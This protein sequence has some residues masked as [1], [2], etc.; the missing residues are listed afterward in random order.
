MIQEK[1]FL[2][3]VPVKN[4]LVTA[5]GKQVRN[6]EILVDLE[7]G[8]F[9]HGNILDA[10]STNK[11]IDQSVK[12]AIDNSIENGNYVTK[13][14]LE[15]ETSA[16]TKSDEDLNTKIK[17]E[18]TRAEG[19]E[20]EISDKLAI[21]DG[22]S[23][24]EGSFRKAIADVI[25]AAPEDLDTLKEIA[26]KL[27]G[28]DDLHT[29][30]N[31]AITEK[32]DASALANEVSRA[33]GAENDLRTAI[34]TKADATALS[35]YVLTTE[36]N[37]QVDT[38]N[39]AIGTKAD[40]TALS[41]YVLTTA[42][43]Q[44]VDTLNAAISAKQDAGNYIPCNPEYSDLYLIDNP[45]SMQYGNQDITI[46]TDFIAFGGEDLSEATTLARNELYF[47]D[48]I[49]S[50]VSTTYSLNGITSS[51]H[52]NCLATSDG[53]FKPISDFVL[54]TELPDVSIDIL[55][56][57]VE[58][59]IT[60]ADPTC[61]RIGNPLFHKSLPIQSEYKGCV[62]KNGKLQYYLNP[63]DWS[64]KSNGE[65]SHLDGT[66]GDVMI[67]TPKF[68]GKSGS[69][70]NKRWVRISTVQID[71]SWTEIPEMFISA[72]RITTFVDSG[73][74]KVASVVN[75]T[76]GYRGG[77][78]RANFD[79]YLSTDK[80]MTDLGKPRSGISR[81]TARTMANNSGQELLCYEFYK[82]IFYWNYV[83][84]YA[85]FNSQKEFNSELTSDGYHQGGLG[86]GLTTWDW[87]LWNTYNGGYAITPCGY[88]NEFGNFS[89]VK[90]IQLQSPEKTLYANRWRGFENPFG[91]IWTNLEGI[92][93][94][95]DAAEA[96][97][98][99]Y[100][101]TDVSKY[102]DDYSLFDIAGVEIDQ[103]GY[104]GT[105][106]LGSKAEIIPYS[107]TGSESTYKCDYHW[108]NAYL[109]E[110]RTLLV[111]GG[112]NN[113]GQAGLGFFSSNTRV[114]YASADVGFRS[115]VRV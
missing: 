86:L 51:Q 99:V 23:N 47:T 42:L 81:A 64:K 115:L 106:D 9:M 76:E 83:I 18:Q 50:D 29:A 46:R 16:R 14:L 94:K 3:R 84:E 22:D 82:W 70:G 114:G 11:L 44:Q 103:D 38:L 61:T 24:T 113:G 35:N 60:V 71:T 79:Q 87:N 30:L 111:G 33:T 80:F 5:P 101:T 109:V 56:Y 31:Q 45:I 100:T 1:D 93:I 43:N 108:C 40:A 53:T 8:E 13:D 105:F 17:A 59:D 63:N 36:L 97:S 10:N 57:G 49:N 12:D 41:N 7:G 88:T 73:R 107:I 58:W 67:H 90:A 55:S 89:G 72:Y 54:K 98:N 26:D 37:Q 110:K 75:T 104:I 112:A 34:G 21:V 95:R 2:Y 32:A 25:A 28:N 92:V 66:D 52:N 77:G 27:A 91:D 78:V 68:Y 20:K 4:A 62:V 69:N 6:P 102:G 39:A 96:N 19:K 85:N 74:G 48:R 15:A 65:P